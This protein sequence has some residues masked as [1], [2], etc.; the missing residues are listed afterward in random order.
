MV[1]RGLC[2]QTLALQWTNL[3]L[4]TCTLH[5]G[6]R[7]LVLLLAEALFLLSDSPPSLAFYFSLCLS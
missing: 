3:T 7:T 4:L 2:G 6:K 1:E 5:L